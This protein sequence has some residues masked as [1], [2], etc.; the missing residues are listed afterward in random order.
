MSIRS[1]GGQIN[2]EVVYSS[3]GQYVTQDLR[4]YYDAAGQ[5]HRYPCVYPVKQYG[6][7]YR[8]QVLPADEY[9]G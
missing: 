6:R 9:A 1:G 7:V 2:R 3:N 8:R 5:P 4:Y